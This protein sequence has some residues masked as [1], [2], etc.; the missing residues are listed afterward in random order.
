LGQRR[1]RCSSAMTDICCI[2]SRYLGKRHVA[3]SVQLYG[4]VCFG[5]FGSCNA[6][7]MMFVVPCRNEWYV[8]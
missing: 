7:C 3:H 1:K 5:S 4:R 2:F 6:G 8:C